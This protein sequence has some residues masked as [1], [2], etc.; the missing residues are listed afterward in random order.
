MNMRASGGRGELTHIDFSA[1][2]VSP[3]L[4]LPL[5]LRIVPHP[6]L[7]E[8]P[9]RPSA[10]SGARPT[11][12]H[13]PSNT[14]Q[15]NTLVSSSV[16]RARAR[17]RSFTHEGLPSALRLFRISASFTTEGSTCDNKR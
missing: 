15:H 2:S 14:F 9:L 12:G 1:I 10:A 3:S 8:R 4:P 17:A 6:W 13:A 5:P 11:P 7:T 16:A